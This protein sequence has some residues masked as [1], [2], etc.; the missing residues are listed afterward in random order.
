[1]P[2][3]ISDSQKISNAVVE[4][5][6]GTMHTENRLSHPAGFHQMLLAV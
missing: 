2:N 3:G 5:T 6:V 4:M 1:M